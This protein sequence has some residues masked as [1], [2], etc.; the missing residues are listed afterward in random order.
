MEIEVRLTFEILPFDI[1]KSSVLSYFYSPL[2]PPPRGEGETGRG[3]S[4][5]YL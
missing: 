2:A 1:R 4:Q 3:R 5:A